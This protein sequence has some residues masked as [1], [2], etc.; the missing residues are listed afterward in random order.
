MNYFV[1][2][3]R[4]LGGLCG[5]CAYSSLMILWSHS[6]DLANTKK[7]QPMFLSKINMVILGLV[8]IGVAITLITLFA[9]FLTIDQNSAYIV[10][11]VSALIYTLSFVLG[12]IIYGFKMIHKLR[13]SNIWEYKFTKFILSISIISTIVW[14]LSILI[15]ITYS[16]GFDIFGNLFGNARN[17]ILDLCIISMTILSSYITINEEGFKRLYGEKVYLLISLSCFSLKNHDSK[18]GTM[19]NSNNYLNTGG[20]KNRNKEDFKTSQE[21]ESKEVIDQV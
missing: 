15:F 4:G 17:I 11:S 10:V 18:T 2:I 6:I 16:F 7:E 5:L 19:M 12:F 3:F 8:Y 13:A 14:I 20:G 1:G 21:L 9:L